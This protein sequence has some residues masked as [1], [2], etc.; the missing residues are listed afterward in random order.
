MSRNTLFSLMRQLG[1]PE[2]N[3]LAQYLDCPL[4]CPSPVFRACFAALRD[5][6]PEMDEEKL[7][8]AL[9]YQATYSGEP[10]D[11]AKLRR[12]KSDMCRLIEDYL[13][14]KELRKSPRLRSELLIEALGRKDDYHLFKETTV[15]RLRR[16]EEAKERGKAYH[17]EAA[18]LY[19]ALYHHP[20]TDV[21][22][23]DKHLEQKS[24][25]HLEQ[26]FAIAYL[27]NAGENFVRQR[28]I[29]A[30]EWLPFM[31]ATSRFEEKQPGQFPVLQSFQALLRLL[32]DPAGLDSFEGVRSL[33]LNNLHHMA[34]SEQQ[35][36]LKLLT[37]KAIWL[38][39]NEKSGANRWV[40][41]LY[42]TSFEM[43][44][45]VGPNG[46]TPTNHFL[47]MVISAAKLGAYDWALDFLQRQKKYLPK[48]EKE[49]VERLSLGSIYF[50]RGKD[51]GQLAHYHMALEHL[52][53]MPQ[54]SH[55]IYNLRARS[56]SLRIYYELFRHDGE[57][58][59]VERQVKNFD[60]YLQGNTT[61][62]KSK[63][64]AYRNF[65]KGFRALLKLTLTP[66]LSKSEVDAFISNYM[67]LEQ[68]VLKDW[69]KEKAE[70]LK[71]SLHR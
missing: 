34:V 32:K 16:L 62:S 43:G 5:A 19:H 71:A 13:V 54:R 7:T 17:A 58:E 59:P 39:A 36:A 25:E 4:H 56:L 52:D 30:H 18:F 69:L 44:L 46:K 67:A 8:D 35:M 60:R 11:E 28:V 53:R 50:Q 33:V 64:A 20:E 45:S 10:L 42:K 26:H 37:T 9:L 61:I 1:K 49:M 38:S 51:S 63:K 24:M 66:G 41:E 15:K 2:M 31:E 47:N 70:E 21:L 40:F 55:V 3:E 6:H 65:L 57:L 27:E 12:L 68:L 22:D 48:P 14:L 23:K 29:D